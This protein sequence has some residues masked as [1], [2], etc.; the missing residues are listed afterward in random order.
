M[1]LKD[2]IPPLTSRLEQR[3]ALEYGAV[4]LTSAV[5]PPKI[6]FRDDGEVT[7][8]QAS[9]KTARHQFG[10]HEIELQSPAMEALLAGADQARSA[11][12][13]ITP[14]SADSGRRS[15]EQTLDLWTR[16][17]VRGLAHWLEARQ[18]NQAE[19]NR[20]R[21]LE[22]SA[23]VEAVLELEDS[24]QVYFGTFF[25][26]SILYSVA[27]PGASQHLSMLAFDVTEFQD[28]RV[29]RILAAHGWYRTVL[30]DLPHFTY[31]GFDEPALR[32]SGLVLSVLKYNNHTYRFWLPSPDLL[33]A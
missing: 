23:Q 12:L 14:R 26:K 28:E 25:D 27:A 15:Y 5:P 16:N 4:F 18:L 30:S 33:K 17:V 6:I 3:L 22:T 10:P 8:F 20:I 19:A 1:N 32:E 21:A 29:E 24:R 2:A 7:S 9:L 31:L 13:T 11:G